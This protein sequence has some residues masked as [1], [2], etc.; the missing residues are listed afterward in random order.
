MAGVSLPRERIATVATLPS[1]LTLPVVG[2]WLGAHDAAEGVAPAPGGQPEALVPS[3]RLEL[4][5]DAVVVNAHP[6]PDRDGHRTRL[7]HL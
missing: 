1:N 2:N 3:L 7:R 4:G 5:D 6:D